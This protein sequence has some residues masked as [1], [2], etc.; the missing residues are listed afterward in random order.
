MAKWLV[1]HCPDGFAVLRD[2]VEAD[3]YEQAYIKMLDKSPAH[4]PVGTICSGIISV[5]KVPDDYVMSDDENT[6]KN[7]LEIDL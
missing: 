2:L 1:T 4:Y 7:I 6:P 3:T 5:T